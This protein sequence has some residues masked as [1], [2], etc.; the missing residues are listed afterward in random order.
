MRNTRDLKHLRMD[1]FFQ[2]KSFIRS[3][4]VSVTMPGRRGRRPKA[5]KDLLKDVEE[6]E[7]DKAGVVTTVGVCTNSSPSSPGVLYLL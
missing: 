6:Y 3:I 1:Q 4:K 7:F 5:I 2:L